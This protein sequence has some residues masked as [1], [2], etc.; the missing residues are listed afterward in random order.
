MAP[1]RSG[2]GGGADGRVNWE[3]TWSDP[4]RAVMLERAKAGETILGGRGGLSAKAIQEGIATRLPA[5][6]K[7]PA[8]ATINDRRAELVRRLGPNPTAKQLEALFKK[9][10]ELW[11]VAP[12]AGVG[13]G[14][15][16]DDPYG[17]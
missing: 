1:A 5:G 6:T 14:L 10:P 11:A 15:L 17:Y 2:R 13:M 4:A 12:A 8:P 3:N 7:A 9:H 16:G